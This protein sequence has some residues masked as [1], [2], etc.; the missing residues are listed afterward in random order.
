MRSPV[1]SCDVP[2]P[3]AL[4]HGK[5]G[6]IDKDR[7][8]DRDGTRAFVDKRVERRDVA[9][10]NGRPDPGTRRGVFQGGEEIERAARGDVHVNVAP[11]RVLGD[12]ATRCVERLAIARPARD[13]HDQRSIAAL[14]NDRPLRHIRILHRPCGI[15]RQNR[16][17]LL[18]TRP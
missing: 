7:V 17:P 18:P 4:P 12:V 15:I 1:H 5:S 11:N 10:R 8:R 16:L 14:A 3:A 6:A 2:V 9:H 13:E